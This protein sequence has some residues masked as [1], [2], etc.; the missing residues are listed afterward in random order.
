MHTTLSLFRLFSIDNI[1]QLL[2]RLLNL[3]RAFGLS[4]LVENTRQC[5]YTKG[6][7]VSLDLL[8]DYCANHIVLRGTCYDA[9]GAGGVHFFAMLAKLGSPL[10]FERLFN[11]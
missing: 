5:T 8:P 11:S 4:E 9:S 3:A 7:Y 6:T 1:N 2:G 10:L